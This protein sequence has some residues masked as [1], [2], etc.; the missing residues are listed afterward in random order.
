[1]KRIVP[2]LFALLLICTIS[3]PTFA[4]PFGLFHGG[5]FQGHHVQ[6]QC[7]P[8]GCAPQQQAHYNP[9]ATYTYYVQPA[10]RVVTSTA[11]CTTGVCPTPQ[12]LE[13]VPT[14]APAAAV[15]NCTN[16]PGNPATKHPA[17]CTCSTCAQRRK[18]KPS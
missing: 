5:W 9:Y 1:M 10:Q 17:D 4:G 14:A 6:Q 12:A 13:P 8:T 15:C 3:T 2:I 7:G 18:P 11:T 16:C